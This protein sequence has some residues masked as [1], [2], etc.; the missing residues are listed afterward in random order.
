LINNHQRHAEIAVIEQPTL[1]PE[2]LA[3]FEEARRMVLLE[4][5]DAAKQLEPRTARELPTSR[6]VRDQRA[7]NVEAARGR[8]IRQ[9][10]DGR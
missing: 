4:Q 8:P 3:I 7:I 5:A 6:L 1:S 2:T 9:P 10:R